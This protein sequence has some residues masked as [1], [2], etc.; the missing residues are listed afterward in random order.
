LTADAKWG[1]MLNRGGARDAGCSMSLEEVRHG[2]L[3]S[4]YM[5]Y[6]NIRSQTGRRVVLFSQAQAYC[7]L[8]RRG[9]PYVR[10]TPVP[11]SS[12]S[13]LLLSS[14]ELSDTNVYEPYIRALTGIPTGLQLAAARPGR[15]S[16]ERKGRY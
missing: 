5:G 6:S 4:K 14:L 10:V 15:A 3:S 1:P 7:R 8:L 2:P 13:S 12:S 11:A 16:P 9:G